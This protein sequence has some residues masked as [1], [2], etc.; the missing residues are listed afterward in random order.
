MRPT[1]EN[2][3]KL[4]DIRLG[5]L[6]SGLGIPFRKAGDKQ[7]LRK[8]GKIVAILEYAATQGGTIPDNVFAKAGCQE[9]DTAQ[10]QSIKHAVVAN[11]DTAQAHDQP[12]C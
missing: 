11:V 10:L 5:K 7:Q 9:E 1:P 12:R 4:S 8:A 3:G 2:L 6:L